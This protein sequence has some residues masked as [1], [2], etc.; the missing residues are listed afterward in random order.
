M[1]VMEKSSELYNI[2]QFLFKYCNGPVHLGSVTV[3]MSNDLG[4]V[5]E[6]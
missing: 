3:R 4:E 1:S 2:A 5:S 6:M